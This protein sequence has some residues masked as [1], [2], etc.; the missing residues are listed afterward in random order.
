MNL[1]EIVCNVINV[2]EMFYKDI[3]VLMMLTSCWDC[4]QDDW[5]CWDVLQRYILVDR[6][7]RLFVVIY[8]LQRSCLNVCCDLSIAKK[9]FE[10]L[11]WFI[12]CKEVVW[13]F[14]NNDM[15]LL[16]V[17]LAL[18]IRLQTSCLKV[19]NIRKVKISIE[20]CCLKISSRMFTVTKDI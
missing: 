11:L 4:L 2:V 14:V 15:N 13:M 7:L 16:R 6:L 19:V 18:L 8:Q 9:L 1:V 17:W 5:C 10:C 20:N 3:T 12:N